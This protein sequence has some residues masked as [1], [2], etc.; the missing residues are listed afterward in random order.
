[1]EDINL[2][3]LPNLL[4]PNEPL[5]SFNIVIPPANKV[6]V[7]INED[8]KIIDVASSVFID[9]TTGWIYIDEG[10]GDKY[11]HA[12]SYYFDKPLMENGVYA[13]SYINGKIIEN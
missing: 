8:N 3:V 1:M 12:Q 11:A 6:Y 5:E 4:E 7:R 9:D 10:Y 13:Y 2:D